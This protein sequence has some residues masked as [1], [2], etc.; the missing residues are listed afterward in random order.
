MKGARAL[1]TRA[2]ETPERATVDAPKRRWREGGEASVALL[3][4][5]FLAFHLPYLPS[6][7]EDLDSINFALGVR[8]FDVAQHQPHPPGYPLFILIG[9]A[10][11]GFIPDEPRALAAVSVIAGTLGVVAIA[12]LFGRLDAASPTPVW[13][14]IAVALA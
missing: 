14:P 6:S 7:L 11:R 8:H 9:K 10:V 3:A 2:R 1:S 12:A 5:V 4:V 13:T